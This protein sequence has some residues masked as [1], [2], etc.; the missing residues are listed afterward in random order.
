MTCHWVTRH[1]F[2]WKTIRIINRYNILIISLFYEISSNDMSSLVMSSARVTSSCV[3]SSIVMNQNRVYS[4]HVTT[5]T[6][7]PISR[8]TGSTWIKFNRISYSEIL[9]IS[10]PELIN[11]RRRSVPLKVWHRKSLDSCILH[12]M[13]ML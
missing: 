9:S 2:R 4:R 12:F 13:P 7:T 5:L 8:S 10:N 1:H 3:T 6:N 11:S